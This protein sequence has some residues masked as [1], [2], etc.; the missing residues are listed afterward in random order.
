MIP[1]SASPSCF[2]LGGWHHDPALPTI[3]VRNPATNAV[4]GRVPACTGRETRAA[5]ELASRAWPAWRAMPAPERA[6]IISKAAQLMRENVDELAA[7]LTAEQGKP[8]KEARGEISYGAG[9][10]EWFAEEARRI[11]GETIPG[12]RAKQRI[13]VLREPVGVV[14]A[15]TPW[16]FPNAMI[17]RKIAPALAAGCCFI[18][19]PAPETP[20]SALAIGALCEKAGLPKGVLQIIT[21]PAEPIAEALLQSDDVRKL[22]FTGSTEVGKL[23]MRGSAD[24]LKRLTLE[25]GG[26]APFIVCED[27]DLEKAASAAMLAKY[28]NAGQ[29]CI[30]VNRFLVHTACAERF[31][32]LLVEKT[33]AL[34]VGDGSDPA[35]D[36]GPLISLDAVDKVRRLLR[37]AEKHGAETLLGQAPGDDSKSLFVPPVVLRGVTPEMALT[38]EEI[39]GPVSAIQT[40]SGDEEAIEKANA[41][42]FGLASYVFTEN[43]SRAWRIVEGLRYG[44]IGLNDSAI[45]AVQ[46][47]FGGVKHSGFGREGGRQGLDEYLE[48]KYVSMEI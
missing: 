5:I 32:R 7:L 34:K 13:I 35:S 17:A 23:L 47:P 4:V 15:I 19:K 43:L 26:N 33:A 20:L 12:N 37:D 1:Q 28:R 18:G 38:R 39:F 2:I 22:S 3:E 42:E 29:T 16:N 10:F 14:A 48:Y 27:A 21:G 44:M 46:A 6:A 8:L 11:Y 31:T 40:F 25:L 24:T 9:Y 41:T 45:S 30:C 36:I